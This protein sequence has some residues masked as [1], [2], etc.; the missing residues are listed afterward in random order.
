MTNLVVL[1]VWDEMVLPSLL[2][3]TLVIGKFIQ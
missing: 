2:Q 3:S 1:L